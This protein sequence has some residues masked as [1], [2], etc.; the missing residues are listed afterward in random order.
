L[1]TVTIHRRSPRRFSV[2]WLVALIVP[3]MALGSATPRIVDAVPAA[4]PAQ[5]RI[6]G[7]EPLSH[8]V[9][10]YLPYWRLDEHSVDTIDYD[11][12]TTIAF[13]GLGIKKSGD[14]DTDWVGY[15][16]YI[17]ADAAAV[18]DAAHARG[19]RVVPTFQLFDSKAG[20]PKMTGFLD[21]LEAQ[22]R[23]IAQA[24]DLMADRLADGASF[25]FEPNKAVNDRADA[26]LG[27]IARFRTAMLERFPQATLT[28][29]TSAGAN[30]KIIGGLV[31]LVDQQ[32]LMTYNYRWSGS[33]VT[34]AIAPLDNTE[35]TVKIHVARALQWAPA[36][37]LLLGVP[38]YGYDWPVKSKTP[39]ADV[40]T[41]NAKYGPVRSVTYASAR[42]FLAT[43]PKV[44]WLYDAVEGS[45]FYTYWDSSHST[46][47]Q[48]YFEEERSLAA[49][50][51][52]AIVTGLAGVGIWTIENDRG[53]DD[54][55]EVLREK[56]YAP[57]HDV[58]V[59][60]S[61]VDIRRTSGSVYVRVHGVA[62]DAGT[63]PER[64]TLRWTIRDRNGRLVKKGDWPKE[65]LYPAERSG[66]HSV[67]RL[68]SAAGLHAGTY[69]LR[70]RFV[71]KTRTWRAEP[72]D[73]R[74]PY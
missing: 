12:V 64:G 17:G 4:A 3:F 66:H 27:F 6:T 36:S 29:A 15:R 51:D 10:A 5:P 74:Q 46:Y 16:E 59:S 13:F 73:F 43:H 52:Y 56:F 25:D 48:V 54:L 20:A 67:V 44:K 49:K 68:G 42:D 72:V 58:A 19:V 22:D 21:S 53:Y 57:V 60:G 26:Y 45:G 55:Y 33:T 39:N 14:I 34:G 9:L 1:T 28:N 71:G 23:F 8:E 35:R 62:R 31:P 38:Y 18:T 47:R 50:Y 65:T 63:V 37:S 69:T 61:M 40:R 2:L 7:I 41:N 11:L 70:V 32:V 30:K 24:L